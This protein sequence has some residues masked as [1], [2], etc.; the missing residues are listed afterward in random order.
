MENKSK[1]KKMIVTQN[2]KLHKHRNGERWTY[3]YSD[4]LK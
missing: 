2:V 4:Q 3:N 1:L